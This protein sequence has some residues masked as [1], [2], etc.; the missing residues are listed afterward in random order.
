MNFIE[1]NQDTRRGKIK[2]PNIRYDPKKLREVSKTISKAGRKRKRKGNPSTINSTTIINNRLK[3]LRD[4]LQLDSIN[5]TLEI[6]LNQENRVRELKSII[7]EKKLELE[8]YRK[9]LSDV[10]DAR[11][12]LADDKIELKMNQIREGIQQESKRLTFDVV[13]QKIYDSR[14]IPT[15]YFNYRRN[16]FT[17]HHEA[18]LD[19]FMQETYI[20]T[21]NSIIQKLL[22]LLNEQPK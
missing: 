9:V 10:T 7:Q 11:N 14:N 1:L 2:N 3:R 18:V 17:S 16:H 4:E 8:S 20:I 19:V 12:K 21:A 22:T 13:K 5:E 15:P 6:L